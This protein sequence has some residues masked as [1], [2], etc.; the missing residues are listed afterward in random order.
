M[1]LFLGSHPNME[2]PIRLW[3]E[4][5][6][7]CM[8]G[9]YVKSSDNTIRMSKPEKYIDMVRGT[10]TRWRTRP[11]LFH[12]PQTLILTTTFQ[13]LPAVPTTRRKRLFPY[14]SI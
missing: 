4:G 12:H 6:Y 5:I 9:M 8:N 13:I 2:N 1:C 10:G 3:Y 14:C 7:I 11:D